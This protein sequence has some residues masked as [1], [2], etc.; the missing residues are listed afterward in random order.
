MRSSSQLGRSLRI[1][2]LVVAFL[3]LANFVVEIGVALFIV[4]PTCF[5]AHEV[6]EAA[7]EQSLAA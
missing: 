5:A 2:V 7:E 6:R 4:I 1:T 3:N